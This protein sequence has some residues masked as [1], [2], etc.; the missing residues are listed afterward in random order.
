[1]TNIG[2]GGDQVEPDNTTMKTETATTSPKILRAGNN[3]ADNRLYIETTK[4]TQCGK[5]KPEEEQTFRAVTAQVLVFAIFAQQ[6]NSLE[7]RQRWV[8]FA[9]KKQPRTAP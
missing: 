8:L 1:M 9:H 2:G 7:E 5:R 4:R 6:S 3:H